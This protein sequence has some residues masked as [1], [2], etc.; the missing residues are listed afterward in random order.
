MLFTSFSASLLFLFYWRVLSISVDGLATKQ[1]IEDMLQTA[2]YLEVGLFWAQAGSAV[3]SV[4]C[5]SRFYATNISSKWEE[6]FVES[7][8]H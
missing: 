1:D 4:V 7:L 8:V 6:Q 3:M 5:C 2:G